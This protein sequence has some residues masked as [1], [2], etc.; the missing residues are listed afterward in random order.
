MEENKLD[1]EQVNRAQAESAEQKD[2]R[3]FADSA[4]DVVSVFVSALLAI[5]VLFTFF[6]RF[7]GVSGTSMVP[8]LNDGDWLA[9][10]AF[11][12]HPQT[13]DIV[14]ITQPNYFNEP[15]VKRVVA[16]EGQTIDLRDGRVYID[17]Q[18]LQEP[19][20]DA[21]VL[22]WEQDVNFPITVEEGCVFV[23]GDNRGG[24]TDSRSS[25]VGQIHVGYIL[26]KVKGRVLPLGQWSVGKNKE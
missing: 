23:M 8:T 7:V 1:L 16:T 20:L 3:G 11:D 14:I 25:K 26:G 10:T 18:R 5:M 22:T 13:G 17:G 15:L 24:S 12:Q 6:F 21:S 4:Y 19:Y 2:P 9:V